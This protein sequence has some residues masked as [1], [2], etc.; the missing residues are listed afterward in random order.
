M[1]FCVSSNGNRNDSVL[2][3][4]AGEHLT[5]CLS[6]SKIVARPINPDCIHPDEDS[7]NEFV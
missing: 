2:L 3:L 5:A 4:L 1:I 7:M 6:I